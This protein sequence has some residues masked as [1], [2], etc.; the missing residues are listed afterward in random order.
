MN[1]QLRAADQR[2]TAMVMTYEHNGQQDF[3][4]GFN[5]SQC[6]ARADQKC[7]GKTWIFN[8]I[9]THEEFFKR[10]QL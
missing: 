5:G 9:K 1:K 10:E 7:K 2:Y 6:V 8:D 3:A 4:I